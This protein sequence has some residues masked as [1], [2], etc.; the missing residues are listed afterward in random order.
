MQVNEMT[1]C[2][3]DSLFDDTSQIIVARPPAPRNDNN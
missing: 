1:L 3:P 2:M